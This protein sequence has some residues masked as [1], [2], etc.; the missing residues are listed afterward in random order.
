MKE[1]S[2]VLIEPQ[3]EG[4]LK[5][6]YVVTDDQRVNVDSSG[7]ATMSPRTSIMSPSTSMY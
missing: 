7:Y 3:N 6:N 1:C 4:N 2:I 5:S